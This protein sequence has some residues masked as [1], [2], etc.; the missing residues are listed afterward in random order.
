MIRTV[1]FTAVLLGIA[2]VAPNRCSAQDRVVT[3]EAPRNNDPVVFTTAQDRQNML[4][5]LGITKPR[6]GRDSNANSPN[7]ANYDQAKATPYPKLP[8]VLET[9]AGKKVTTPEQWWNERRP[10]L[11]ELLEREVYGR[12]PEN[13]PKVRWEVRETREVEAGGKPAVLRHIVGVVN[14]SSCPEIKVNISMSLTLPK[15]AAG[16]VPVL[17]S[18]GWTPFEPSPFVPRAQGGG[19]RPPSKE[20]TLIGAGW[21]CATLNP[22]TVQDDA[23]GWQP[24]RFSP[25]A[26]PDARPTGAGLTRGIIGLTNHGQPRTPDQWGALRAWAW[27]A[28]RG[29]DYL[30]TVPEVDAKRVGI[31]G[32]SR[33]GK[34]ALVTTAFDRRFAMGLIASSGAGGTKLLRRDFG[35]NLENLATTGAYHWMAGN[36]LKYSAEESAFGRKTADDLP[37]DSHMTLALCAPRLTFISHGIPERGDAH[38]LDHQGSFMAAIA[39]QPVFRLLGARDLGR[40]DDYLTEKMPGVNVDLLDGALAWRQH[41][42]GH[43][44]GPNVEHFV[45]WAAARWRDEKKRDNPGGPDVRSLKEAAGDRFKFGVG[46]GQRVLER[47]EDAALIRQHFQILTPENC[48]KP[49][50]IHPAEER[51]NFGAA[52]RFVEFARANNLE[53]VGHCLVWA[54]DDRTDKWMTREDGKPVSRETLLRRIETHIETVV[55]RYA[56]VATMWDVVNEAVADSGDGLL[57]DSVYSRTTG[58]DFI[59]TAFKAARAKDPDALLIYNDYNDHKPDKRKKVI[60]LLTQLKQKGAPVDAYGMQGHF[61]LGDEVFPQ[62]RE[63]FD[64]LRKLGIKVVVSELDIDVVPRSRWWADDGKHRDELAKYDPYKGGLPDE[65]ARQQAEQYAALFRLFDEYSNLIERVSFWNLHDGES[66]LNDFPWKRVNHPLLFDR[67]LKPK[68]AFDAVY[69]TL[70]TPRNVHA[71]VE[72]RDPNSRMAH[73]QLIAKTKQGTIDIYFE[74]DSITRRWGATDYPK[75]L[76]HWRRQF[77]GWNAADFGWGGDT[78]H[79]ILWRLQNGEFD[80]VSPKVIVLQAGTNNLPWRGPANEEAVADVGGGITAIVATFREKAPGATVV[81]TA[82]FPRPQNK[83]LAPAIGRINEQLARLADGKRVR[84]VNINDR[85]TDDRGELLPGVS[86]DGVHL[87][88]KGYDAWAAA[89]KP[90]FTELLGPAGETDHAPPPTGDPSARRETSPGGND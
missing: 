24:R 60:E 7:P 65:V 43:T 71:P 82:L 52:D 14:N 56:D 4:D 18:F 48:M 86:A 77:H 75:F 13:V 80:G 39:A 37:V 53:V 88:E 85:L 41:D 47:P 33:Y 81:L 61:E 35:E 66:W 12:I 51:W 34:A 46:V 1:S 76:D 6:P 2:A 25:N 36:Y 44:D 16:P 70:K 89:L 29:L 74:G 10:E 31:A 79:N 58:I 57:R 84:F 30:E 26:D 38:W 87:E 21:G 90:I 69:A 23:G 22:S 78:T 20:D 28:S 5:Q 27:G 63:T 3:P 83:A 19:P 50:S 68:P 62:L 55:G 15:G 40:S 59:V 45:R 67:N 42:G 73:Q 54:K 8:E 72:R 17:M 49:Q 64:A 9:K 32:V 11:V